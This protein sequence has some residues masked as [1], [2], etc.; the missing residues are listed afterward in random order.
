MKLLLRLR[1]KLSNTD[2]NNIKLIYSV[3]YLQTA[4][5]QFF[6]LSEKIAGI[7]IDETERVMIIYLRFAKYI[8]YRY[9]GVA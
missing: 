9:N 3:C 7:V 4:M 2:Y 8:C 6:S 1:K 5:D